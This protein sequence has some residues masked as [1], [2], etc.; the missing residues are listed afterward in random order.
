MRLPTSN[1][2]TGRFAGR[3]VGRWSRWLLVVAALVVGIGGALPSAEA[4][5]GRRHGRVSKE[6]SKARKL[7]K[8]GVAKLRE[9]DYVAA[10]ELFTRTVRDARP[11]PRSATHPSTW[12]CFAC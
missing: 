2:L 12:F 5:R 6:R 9:G 7:V 3:A 10:L 1:R 11:L 8:Q 4:R